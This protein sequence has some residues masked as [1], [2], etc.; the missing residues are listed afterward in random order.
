M[1]ER[2]I[3]RQRDREELRGETGSEK[4]VSEAKTMLGRDLVEAKP[5]GRNGSIRDRAM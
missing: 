4:Q 3:D 5:T 1:T 2:Q